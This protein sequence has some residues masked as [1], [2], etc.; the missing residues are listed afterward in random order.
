M[1]FSFTEEQELEQFRCGTWERVPRNRLDGGR[2]RFRH[3]LSFRVGAEG[4]QNI[5]KIIIAKE[6]LGKEFFS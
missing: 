3:C 5:M 1:D 4:A 6:L 2:R